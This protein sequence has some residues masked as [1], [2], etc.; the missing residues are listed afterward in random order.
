[1]TYIPFRRGDLGSVATAGSFADPSRPSDRFRRAQEATLADWS[2]TLKLNF[3]DGEA[4]GRRCLRR[5]H[6]TTADQRTSTRPVSDAIMCFCIFF[7]E[8]VG[9]LFGEA[10]RKV[11]TVIWGGEQVR[12]RTQTHTRSKPLD[13]MVWL[14]GPIPRGDPWREGRR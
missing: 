7:L 12:S 1:M 3:P 10:E 6:G 5:P 13:H 2:H 9:S 11:Q 14:L 4:T 8:R